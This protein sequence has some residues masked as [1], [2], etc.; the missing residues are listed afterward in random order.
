MNMELMKRLP[1]VVVF[2]WTCVL[3]LPSLSHGQALPP[4]TSSGLNTEVSGPMAVGGLTQF[5][6]TG[7]TRPGGG[8]NLFHSFG[9]FNVPTNNV[10]NFLNETALP[11]SNILGRVTGGNISNIFGAIQ[12]QGFGDAN[13]FLMNPAGFLFGPNATV[14]VSGMMAFTS[15]DYLRLQD[16]GG[17]NAGIFHADAA[18][19]SVLTTAPVVAY[20]FL[21]SNPGAI[22]VQGSLLSVTPGRSLSLV[23]GNIT[24]QSGMLDDGVTNQPASLT[25]RG[26]QISLVS[27]ASSG[28]TLLS[29]LQSAPNIN[30][31]SFTAMGNI[32]LSE[33][34]LDVSADEAGTVQIR[35]GE[36]VIE[37]A[38]LSADTGEN[39]GAPV[40]IDIEV[41][42]DLSIFATQAS[43]LT[44]KAADAGNA[45]EIRVSSSK[46][47]VNIAY[48]EF[49]FIIDTSTFGA[50]NA[51]KVT[52]T[53]TGDLTAVNTSTGGFGVFIDSG[54]G[55]TGNGGDVT[56]R[57]RN[58]LISGAAINL[59]DGFFFG[60]GS[61]GNLYIGGPN[62]MADSLGANTTILSTDATSAKAGSIT[63]EAHDIR[64]TNNTS[65]SATS[66]LGENPI[67]INADQ[68][69]MDT[70]VRVQATTIGPGNGGG[71][72]FTGKRLEMN[73]ES[74][75]ITNTFGDGNA[76]DIRVNA[77]DY[78]RFSDDPT[79]ITP[80][81][82]FTNSI[83]FEGVISS[84]NAGAI[85]VL[86]PKLEMTGGARISTTTRTAGQGGDVTL[87]ASE[88]IVIS[89]QRTADLPLENFGLGGSDGSGIFTRTVGSDQCGPV[90]GN[91]GNQIIHA[92]QLVLQNGGILD[93]GTTGNG[94]GG[95]IQ[96]NASNIAISGTLIDGT[97][98]GV[99]SRTIATTSDAG[100]GG[101]IS[102]IAGQS[103]SISDGAAVSAS[104]SGPGNAGNI[105]VNANDISINGG[106][107]I[108]AA[109]TG[110]GN[111]GT[112]TIQ[113]PSSP[114]N[115]F[116][117][118]GAGSGV[119]TNTEDT[120]AGG[121]ISVEANA[122]TLQNGG[123][124]SASTTGTSSSATGGSI[125]ISGGQFVQMNNGPS[126]TASSTGPGDAGNISIDAG[127]QLV[128]QNSFIKTEAAQAGGGNIEIRAV[129][130][131]QLENSTV[132]TSVLGG[133]G[134]GGNI[135]ID[136]NLVLLQNSQIIA[137]AV[138]GAG[139]NIS[140]TTNLLL[141][142]STSLI[143]ASSQFGQQGNIVIQSPVSPASGKLVP[144]GQKPLI[145]TS[146]LSQRCAALA[147]GSISS[148]TVAG[149]DSLPAEPGG[150]LS[151]PV[152]L[153]T[154]ESEDE[155]IRE[156]NGSMSDGT[157]L[158]SLRKIAPSGFLT[159]AFAADSSGC[160]S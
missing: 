113:G 12:T 150:W 103:V 53:A 96:V 8:T 10:A 27:V 117:V 145:A 1:I 77:S 85:Q 125:S 60:T 55:G 134:S 160:Q 19:I 7:G 22:T 17:G 49:G 93:S 106:A 131:V 153:S 98:G 46:M 6:I 30:G 101:N 50:G 51:G 109:S 4:I 120:G 115:S 122:V 71:I 100:A 88:G 124:V 64:L 159:Q 68:L 108:T 136:P 97:P 82:L 61:A 116:L 13:L 147:G 73:N 102:V 63:L 83:G 90:C 152:A 92:G 146:L 54:T 78:V 118:D 89:G 114:A 69:S 36:L 38:T 25:G 121:S 75:F 33:A 99:F 23:G 129:D 28:E 81:G 76:G 47:D 3:G 119:F 111:A 133:S 16:L 112:V 45:G 29:T 58:G 2:G 91:G 149:R 110:A 148:F 65:V 66:L 137:Q 94:R 52:L 139:G 26:G 140:I 15:A 138:Q 9:T 24:V 127:P 11:T 41:T 135:T 67:T 34:L 79:I 43:V 84:G 104:T 5:N 123:T 130:L 20:G 126:I 72:A 39:N 128:M 74:A 87:T 132:S 95:S 21:G 141:P 155:T 105:L 44:A 143:S 142:D 37:N 86:T 40:A 42:G 144:L 56:I 80:S 32:N 154:P 31:Q 35:G 14:N 156:A 59:G 70:V 57:A 158:L 48:P 157:P 107:T 18:Q 151:S 62:G